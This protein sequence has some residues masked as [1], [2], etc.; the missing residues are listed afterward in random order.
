VNIS[1]TTRLLARIKALHPP[2]DAD[3][4]AAL[5]T[6]AEA[7]AIRGVTSLP[8]AER[9]VALYYSDPNTTNP[10]IKPGDVVRIVRTLRRDRGTGVSGVL[11]NADP[12]NAIGY[13]REVQALEQAA[14]DGR[15]DPEAYAASGRTLSGAPALTAAA[16]RRALTAGPDGSAPVEVGRRLALAAPRVT[17]RVPT[18]NPAVEGGERPLAATA[19]TRALTGREL[20]V[21]EAE[22]ERQLA[23]L[24][25]MAAGEVP[26]DA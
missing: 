22:R 8:D 20:A 24:A 6:W 21:I 4:E 11:P 5:A 19:P 1:D 18:V 9:A 2:F 16:D 7:L 25:A 17:R 13:T 26:G 10:W 15:L 14:A 23:A 3:S 12:Q